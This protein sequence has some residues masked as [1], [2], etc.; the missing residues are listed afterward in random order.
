MGCGKDDI[1]R[2]L[3]FASSLK[4]DRCEAGHV[5]PLGCEIFVQCGGPVD[6]LSIIWLTLDR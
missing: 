2:A 5:L 6:C 3:F 4:A 1:R